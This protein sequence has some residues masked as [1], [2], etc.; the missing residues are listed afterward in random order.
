M[1]HGVD[2]LWRADVYDGRKVSTV[3]F[4]LQSCFLTM[5]VPFANGPDIM[6]C[7]HALATMGFPMSLPSP[8]EGDTIADRS[9]GHY[10]WTTTYE[11][12]LTPSPESGTNQSYDSHKFKSAN[13]HAETQEQLPGTWNE[14]VISNRSHRRQ[15]GTNIAHSCSH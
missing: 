1:P 13:E 5:A 4:G 14:R 6:N 10:R 7:S 12:L 9:S 8:G 15:P 2:A 11:S 3:G